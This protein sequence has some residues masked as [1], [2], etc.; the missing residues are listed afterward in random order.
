MLDFLAWM[1]FKGY[2]YRTI[3]VHRSA[4]SSVLPYIDGLPIGQLPFVIQLLGGI[5]QNNPSLPRYQYTWDID[6]VLKSLLKLPAS[7]NLDLKTLG[8]KLAI[9]LAL[10]SPKRVSEI[11]RLDR[12]FMATRNDSIV[13][14]LPGLSKTQKGC[15]SRTVKYCK[16][17]TKKI[18]VVA[19]IPE[20]EK[21]RS[22]V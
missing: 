8:K 6:I 13:F 18:C 11:S 19:C 3:N 21:R 12:R 17:G 22:T 2:E 7:K 14:H 10:T 9:L 16:F 5:L 20:Y 15:S 4:I 1:H